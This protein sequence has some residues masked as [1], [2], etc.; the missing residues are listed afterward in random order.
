M[1]RLCSG[2]EMTLNRRSVEVEIYIC[3]TRSG[4]LRDPGTDLLKVGIP[5]LSADAQIEQ[6]HSQITCA[7]KP[8]PLEKMQKF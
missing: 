6:P 2:A 3:S 4:N 1:I 8:R 5:K 7:F